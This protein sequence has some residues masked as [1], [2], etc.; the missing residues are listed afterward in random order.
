M[1][2]LI[3]VRDCDG[4]CCREGPRFPNKDGSDCIYRTAGSG[5]DDT[6]L[7]QSGCKLM[8]GEE[9]VPDG[10]SVIFVKQTVAKVF[11]DTCVDW[12]QNTQPMKRTDGTIGSTAGCC[13][14]WR[15]DGA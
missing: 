3:Q 4:Q 9:P 1:L 15:D 6:R 14:Q 12:P 11:Q 8:S 7:A 10:P 13:W 2:Q 5:K